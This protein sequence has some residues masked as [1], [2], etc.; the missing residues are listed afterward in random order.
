MELDLRDPFGPIVS[1]DAG[2]CTQIGIHGRE[3]GE[4]P[5]QQ[6]EVDL[7]PSH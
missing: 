6:R 1:R 7:N 3:E 2:G 5:S 4:S